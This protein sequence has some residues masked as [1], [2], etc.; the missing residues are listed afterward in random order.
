MNKMT[1][2]TERKG[3]ITENSTTSSC[4]TLVLRVCTTKVYGLNIQG[5]LTPR[6]MFQTQMSRR[7]CKSSF[8]L[9]VIWIASPRRCLP[10]NRTYTRPQVTG[11]I[12]SAVEDRIGDTENPELRDVRGAVQSKKGV[13]T[14]RTGK[15]PGRPG[16]SG[17]RSPFRA[18]EVGGVGVLEAA[19]LE[20]SSSSSAV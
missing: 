12:E 7:M 4:E 1:Q 3:R 14:R 13:G 18:C 5:V 20:V 2:P 9:Q 16:D 19:E 17:G 10:R 6:E 11:C 8:N 15:G